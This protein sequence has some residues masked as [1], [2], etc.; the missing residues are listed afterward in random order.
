MSTFTHRAIEL[1][2]GFSLVGYCTYAIY[3]GRVLGKFRSYSRSQEPWSFWATV[4]I[5]AGVGAMFS[6]WDGFMARL[7]HPSN[8]RCSEP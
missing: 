1:I 8:L 6:S 4:L 2:V 5:T 3:T 7:T